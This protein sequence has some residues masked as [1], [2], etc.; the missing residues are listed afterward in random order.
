LVPKDVL[1]SG[2][3]PDFDIPLETNRNYYVNFGSNIQVV[4]PYTGLIRSSTK[5]DLAAATRLCDRL[6]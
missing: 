6:S 5:K 2:R 1:L 4:D 3:T